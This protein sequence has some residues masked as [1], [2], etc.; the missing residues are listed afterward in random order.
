M[1]KKS[2]WTGKRG[3]YEGRSLTAKQRREQT[4][5]LESMKAGLKDSIEDICKRHGWELPQK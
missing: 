1:Q 5:L 2:R 3:G 4:F